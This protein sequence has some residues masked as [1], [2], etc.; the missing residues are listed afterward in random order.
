MGLTN[1]DGSY[2]T[3][4]EPKNNDFTATGNLTTDKVTSSTT[5]VKDTFINK[6][7]INPDRYPEIVSTLLKY[8]EGSP[9]SVTYFHNHDNSS[10]TSSDLLTR[11]DDVH[12]GWL[13]IIN[14]E[15]KLKHDLEF[16]YDP[17][18]TRSECSG[19]GYIYPGFNPTVGDLFL[20]TVDTNKIGQFKINQV[21]RLTIKRDTCYSIS[22]NLVDFVDTQEIE[23]LRATSDETVYFDRQRYFDG[24][25]TLL[26]SSDYL[27]LQEALS[28]KTDLTTLYCRKFYDRLYHSTFIRPDGAYDPYLVKFLRTIVGYE[29]LGSY[30]NTLLHDPI[31]EYFNIYALLMEPKIINVTELLPKYSTQICTKN[32][33]ATHLNSLVNKP[34]IEVVSTSTGDSSIDEVSEWYVL[35]EAYYNNNVDN[36]SPLEIIV[37]NY[38]V[39]NKINPSQLLTLVK[40][41]KTLTDDK[42]FYQV[43]IYIFLLDQLTTLIGR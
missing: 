16:I 30:C 10:Y 4:E 11:L 38:T 28:L 32:L 18:T 42:F 25:H 41:Y 14:F 34:Y 27:L 2:D 35:S 6:T 15:F 17:E 33:S 37:H 31:G 22:F 39:N 12:Q 23:A 3:I 9:I 36:F 40:S 13:Q 5:Y 26:Y 1:I 8:G 24:E 29:E 20:Y 7:A 19:E 43:P 21:E